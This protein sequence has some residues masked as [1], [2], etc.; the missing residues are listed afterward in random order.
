MLCKL[1]GED[2]KLVDAHIIPK[3]FHRIDPDDRQPSRLVTNVEGRYPQKIRK[4]IY[5]SAILC[6]DCEHHF[7]RWDDYADNIFLKSW[8]KFE[9]ISV[10]GEDFGFRL[11]SYDYALLK[12]FFLSVLWRAAVSQ[13]VM[14]S[15]IQLGP[16]EPILRDSI[17]RSAPGDV[18]YFGVVLQAFDSTE[19]GI[20]NPLLERFSGVRFCRIYLS[21]IIAFIKVDSRP[22]HEPFKSMALGATQQL[23]L[24]HKNFMTSPERRIMRN[25]ALADRASRDQD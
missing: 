13:H 24:A 14:Y 23:V 5:D 6:E 2:K 18:D 3:S 20:L 16:R 21:H 22:F 8:G 11:S 4:G 19:I 17:L 12:M 10:A 1:C 15:K 7:S 25:L 9:K